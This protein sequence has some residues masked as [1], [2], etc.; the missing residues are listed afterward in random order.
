MALGVLTSLTNLD[1]ADNSLTGALPEQAL[2]TLTNLEYLWLDHNQFSGTI[3][4][5]LS[6]L[7]RLREFFH[8]TS[9]HETAVTAS[10]RANSL[11]RSLR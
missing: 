1:V 2:S 10:D 9:R 5:D 11:M 8:L 3:P 7:T 4:S 6:K